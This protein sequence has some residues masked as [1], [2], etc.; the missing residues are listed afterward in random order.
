MNEPPARVDPFCDRHLN[1]DYLAL[2]A[3]GVLRDIRSLPIEVQVQAA[4]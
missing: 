2:I 1:D 3:D 4:A